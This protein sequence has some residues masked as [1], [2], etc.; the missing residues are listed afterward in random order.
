MTSLRWHLAS[1]QSQPWRTTA[2]YGPD[3]IV[4]SVQCDR[5]V[6]V[7]EKIRDFWL[8]NQ[9]SSEIPTFASFLSIKLTAH[10]EAPKEWFKANVGYYKDGW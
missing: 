2:P 7:V 1:G 3:G 10:L 5:A 9:K 4:K 8:K 6:H